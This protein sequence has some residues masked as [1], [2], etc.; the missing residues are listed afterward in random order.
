MNINEF[1][2]RKKGSWERYS[3]LLERVER[4]NYHALTPDEIEEFALLYRGLSADLAAART[5]FP[6]SELARELNALVSRGYAHLYVSGPGSL[7]KF[8]GFLSIGYP[9]L[10]KKHFAAVAVSLGLFLFF[11]LAGYVAQTLDP[12][13]ADTMVPREIVR[14]FEQDLLERGFAERDIP[15]AARSAFSSQLMTNNIQVSFMAFAGGVTFGL[16]TLFIAVKNAIMLGA[17]GRLFATHGVAANFLAF[18]MPHGV[19]E[20]SA[21]IISAAAGLMIGYAMINPGNLSRG[22]SLRRG[23]FQAVQ[24]MFGVV[25]MLILA[26]IIEA[27]FT[28]VKWI[29]DTAKLI[30]SSVLFLIMIGY[31]ARGFLKNMDGTGVAQK[32]G[33]R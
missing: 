3:A 13:I 7:R 26:G 11:A 2:H 4:R 17:L 20:L 33:M 18:V 10:I 29:P 9:M 15:F 21:I 23:A 31:F 24:L 25:P 12:R 30:F 27:Y 19:I 1:V 22:D 6:D 5:H 28:P 8:L 16:L 14:H 32:G